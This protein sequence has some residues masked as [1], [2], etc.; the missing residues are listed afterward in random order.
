M[1]KMRTTKKEKTTKD[2][3]VMVPIEMN[4]QTVMMKVFKP[5]SAPKSITA[6]C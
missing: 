1:A 3:Y 6:R 4:G 2:E 5:E